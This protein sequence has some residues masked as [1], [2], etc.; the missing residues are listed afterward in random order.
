MLFKNQTKRPYQRAG[1]VPYFYQPGLYH[2]LPPKQNIS[3]RLYSGQI[4]MYDFSSDLTGK[5]YFFHPPTV[6]EIIAH[7]YFTVPKS[8]PV[9]SL[10]GDKKHTAKLGLDDLIGQIRQRYSVYQRNI[11]DLELSKCAAINSIHQHEAW[12]GPT[13]SK[14]EYSVNKRLDQLYAEAR[15]ERINLWRD[16]SRL[17]VLLPE[18]AQNYLATYRKV[19]ILKDVKGDGL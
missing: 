9:T 7:G 10:I 13:N 6:E 17:R 1:Y 11:Y 8:D 5:T 14:V 16:V 18:S 3:V 15:E 4:E 12:H 2:Y 19:S